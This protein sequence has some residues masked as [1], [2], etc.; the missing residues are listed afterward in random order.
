MFITISVALA[1]AIVGCIFG[2]VGST[3][4]AVIGL[5]LGAYIA[6]GE[7]PGPI[8]RFFCS[9][10][11]RKDDVPVLTEVVPGLYEDA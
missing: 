10:R 6:F 11:P 5:M 8:Y 1:F 9:P 7:C 2:I 4:G 3:L